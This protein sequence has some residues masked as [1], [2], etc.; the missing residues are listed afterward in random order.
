MP[1]IK[2]LLYVASTLSAEG[3]ECHRAI[4]P[5]SIFGRSFLERLERGHRL[6]FQLT[7]VH[8]GM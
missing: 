5:L 2:S 7:E 6:L 1:S 4:L 3:G 8:F